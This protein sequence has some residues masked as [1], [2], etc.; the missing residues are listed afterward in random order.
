MTIQKYSLTSRIIHWFMAVIILFLLGLGIYMT[1]FLPIDSPSHLPIYSLHKTLGVVAL[2][3]IFIRIINRFVKKPPV[4][5][6]TMPKYEQILTHLG[7][8]GLYVLM[9]VVP[10]SGF[11]MS[12]SF[13]FRVKFFGLELPM[14][15]S[16]NFTLGKIFATIH[17]LGAYTLLGLIVAHVGAVIK[18][19]FFDKPENDILKRMI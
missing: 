19:R 14:I 11:L 2:I 8:F 17:E 9:I 5:P 13:G 16:T 12:N 4:L 3:F 1:K 6:T 7:H 18:H 10:L 15:I